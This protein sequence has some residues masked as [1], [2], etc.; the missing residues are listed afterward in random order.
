MVGGYLPAQQ[1]EQCFPGATPGARAKR[2]DYQTARSASIPAPGTDILLKHGPSILRV[3]EQYTR[4]AADKLI[5]RVR[6]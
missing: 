4:L 3:T 5:C 1:A 2:L 6:S